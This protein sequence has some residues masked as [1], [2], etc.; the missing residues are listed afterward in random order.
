MRLLLEEEELP[1]KFDLALLRLF[2]D[3]AMVALTRKAMINI[4]IVFIIVEFSVVNFYQYVGKKGTVKC[5]NRGFVLVDF[6]HVKGLLFRFLHF[7]PEG[8]GF[9]YIIIGS[10]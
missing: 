1:D 7:L 5:A 2:W 4:P 3:I 8:R 6:P 10:G 9:L